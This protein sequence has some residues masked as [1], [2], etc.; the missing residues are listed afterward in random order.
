MTFELSP[1]HLVVVLGTV[2]AALA[3]YI[4]R[5]HAKLARADH[6]IK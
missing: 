6:F 3:G 4:V 2:V 5:L 1:W